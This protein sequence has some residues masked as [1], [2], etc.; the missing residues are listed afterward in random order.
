MNKK[1]LDIVKM[2]IGA[3]A[4]LC[5]LC[6]WA[7]ATR[8]GTTLGKLMPGPVEVIKHFIKTTYTDV[9]PMTILGHTGEYCKSRC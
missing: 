8:E 3:L 1:K 4:I 2:A 6:L 9:G 5:F 7:F